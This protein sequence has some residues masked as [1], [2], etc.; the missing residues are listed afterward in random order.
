MDFDLTTSII[1][2]GRGGDDPLIW[3]AGGLRALGVK[4][5]DSLWLRL[6]DVAAALTARG[7][8]SACDI[9]LDVVGP[10]CPWN[11]SAWRLSVDESEVHLPAH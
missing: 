3:W 1:L 6:I 7:Y 9:V 2:H 10:L 4:A 11:Q 8:S 5:S